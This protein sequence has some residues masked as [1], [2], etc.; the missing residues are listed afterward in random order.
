M[1]RADVTRLR[2]YIEWVS[3]PGIWNLSDSA[4]EE[5]LY[6]LNEALSDKITLHKYEQKEA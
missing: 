3:T 5:L 4:R 2:E 6:Y 1:E